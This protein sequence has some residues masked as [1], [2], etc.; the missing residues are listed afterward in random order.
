LES[1][2]SFLAAATRAN[3]ALL[4]FWALTPAAILATIFM[5]NFF[6]AASSSACFLCSAASFSAW[7]LYISASRL[8][9][10]FSAASLS[11]FSFAA[12]SAII[13]FHLASISSSC[14]FLMAASLAASAASF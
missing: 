1:A 5:A 2:T 9:A 6:F 10:S 11:A 4:A 3:L 14:F 8:A 12:F 13:A 7:I